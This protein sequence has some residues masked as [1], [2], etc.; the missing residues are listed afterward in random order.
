MG[1]GVVI[2]SVPVGGGAGGVGLGGAGVGVEGA[3]EA[4]V[5]VLALGPEV[6]AAAAPVPVP[7][8]ARRSRWRAP[9]ARI[10]RRWASTSSSG[11]ALQSRANRSTGAYSV[12][13]ASPLQ[14]RCS[15]D[16][17]MCSRFA[18]TP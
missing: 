4:G 16:V 18:S 15:V 6:A 9:S 5:P 12:G 1:A 3:G 7:A 11:V 13:T 8:A 14:Y 2:A 17:L 10:H